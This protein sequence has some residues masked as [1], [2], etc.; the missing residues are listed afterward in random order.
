MPEIYINWDNEVLGL[1]FQRIFKNEPD[2]GPN[3][4]LFL[5]DEGPKHGLD[6]ALEVSKKEENLI[7]FLGALSERDIV[8]H[9]DKKY[10]L[11]FKELI[12]KKNVRFLQIPIDNKGILNIYR[13]LARTLEG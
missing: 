6:F 4:K 5:I 7:I 3:K 8:Y 12:S 9:G 2:L 1:L 10:A 13:D 11:R